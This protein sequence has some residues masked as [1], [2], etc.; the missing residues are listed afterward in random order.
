MPK[1]IKIDK[2]LLEKLYLKDKIGSYDIAKTLNCSQALIMKKL[3]AY[4]I[5]TRTIQEAKSLTPPKYERHDFDGDLERKAYLI[6]FRLGDLYVNKTHPNSPTI[7][8]SVNTTK[9]EQLELIEEL[10]SQY[11]HVRRYNRDKNG[12]INIRCFVN[13]SFNFLLKKEDKIEDWILGNEKYFFSFLGG[14]IDAE[15]NFSSQYNNSFCINTQDKNILHQI[16]LSLNKNGIIC[17]P[18]FARKAGSIMAGV[19]SNKDVWQLYIYNRE[20][21]MKLIQRI[22]K[23]IKHGKRRADMMILLSKIK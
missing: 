3:R 7:R 13:S 18:R 2:N 20:N 4:S 15:G 8:I 11:G 9:E 17:K 10:F 23:Y 16:S 6:G 12:A 22:N 14:Y 19:R 21:L 5:K 1:A